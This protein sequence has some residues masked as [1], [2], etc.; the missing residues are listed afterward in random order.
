MMQYKKGLDY[1]SIVLDINQLMKIAIQ[2]D[3]EIYDLLQKDEQLFF[4][5]S[6]KN[7]SSIQQQFP[8]ISLLNTTGVIGF[9]FRNIK[10][11]IRVLC[12]C[13]CI[14]LW[15]TLSQTIFHIE[16]TGEKD[17]VKQLIQM[18][19]NTLGY[20]IPMYD[21]NIPQMKQELRK[22]LE[23]DI[24]WL[25]VIKK[26]SELQISYTPKEF[27]NIKSLERNELIAKKDGVIAYFDVQHGYKTVLPNQLVTKGDV[28]VSNMLLDSK[29]KTEELYVKGR[30][31]AYTFT[32]VEVSLD[33]GSINN[34]FTFYSCLLKARDEVS[35]NFKEDDKIKEENILQFYEDVGKIKMVVQYQ[36]LE[37]ITTP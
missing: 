23:N 4:Y 20:K 13:I 6:V 2:Q 25:E 34:P 29:N 18:E 30:V 32:K 19:L 28:L 16:I 27:V 1:Y 31:F 7:R 26:G 5:A 11:P 36:L 21:K 22:A 12:L 37:D 10:N 17:S 24:A 8:N 15:Y 14:I 35:S 3:W 33:S 9:L